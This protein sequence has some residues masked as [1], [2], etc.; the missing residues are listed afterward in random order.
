MRNVYARTE[1]I[2]HWRGRLNVVKDNIVPQISAI[3]PLLAPAESVAKVAVNLTAYEVSQ[4]LDKNL[5]G[6]WN[7]I[8][9]QFTALTEDF[10]M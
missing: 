8:F 5:I 6:L 1:N 10:R 7:P 3:N 2:E 9:P 4:N